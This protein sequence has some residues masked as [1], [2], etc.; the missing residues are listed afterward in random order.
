M[1]KEDNSMVMSW[2]LNCVQHE[3]AT[4]IAYLKS[5]KEMWEFLEKIYSHSKNISK[6]FQLEEELS[7]LRQGDSDLTQYL[8]TL[9]FMYEHLKSLF[10]PCKECYKS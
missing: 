3:R 6:F 1:C 9:T 8:T 2:I 7:Q 4:A 5:T 10:P